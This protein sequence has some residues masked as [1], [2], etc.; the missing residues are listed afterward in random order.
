VER[1]PHSRN[2]SGLA[3][4]E[5]AIVGSLLLMLVFAVITF[6]NILASKSALT[7]AVQDS[8][9]A[10][11]LPQGCSGHAC[12]VAEMK[13]IVAAHTGL[14]SGITYTTTT[15]CVWNTSGVSSG[16]AKIVA[17]RTMPI[18]VIGVPVTSITLTA[19]GMMPCGSA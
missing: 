16:N 18:S 19:T 11:S 10:A 9:R 2:D 12:S 17:K 3:T 6:G 14:S 8:A 1:S 4:V 5:F 13:N 7:S 15:T